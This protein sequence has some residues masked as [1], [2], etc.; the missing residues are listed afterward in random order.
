[1]PGLTDAP[2]LSR[3]HLGASAMNIV[4]KACDI[5]DYERAAL[6]QY[7]L[8]DCAMG[9]TKYHPEKKA[10]G[11]LGVPHHVLHGYAMNVATYQ[12]WDDHRTVYA[13]DPTVMDVIRRSGCSA[14]SGVLLRN[15]PHSNPFVVFPEPIDVTL[16]Q[17][18]QKGKLYGVF[19]YGHVGANKDPNRQYCRT[20]DDD[21]THIGMT[22]LTGVLDD[23]G[24]QIDVDMTRVSVPLAERFTVERAVHDVLNG[25]RAEVDPFNP[26]EV[27]HNSD[28]A[29]VRETKS[30]VETVL[31][32]GLAVLLY[33][34]SDE[35]EAKVKTTPKPKGQRGNRKDR[36]PA[37]AAAP[38]AP[39]TTIAHV[40]WRLGADLRAARATAET[41]Y[42]RGGTG[43]TQPPMQRAGHFKEQA[44]GTRWSLRKLIFVKPYWTHKDQLDSTKRETRVV[45]VR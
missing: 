36:K 39:R 28:P 35:Y 9:L 34:V 30:W 14:V 20:D 38:A 44:Y 32:I 29:T 10:H 3:A 24:D 19:L 42:R 16:D 40:G 33:L 27:N 41:E 18:G 23:E 45:P 6:R 15:L 2:V 26:E 37:R 22:F 4:T 43:R 31:R 17:T 5:F 13:M 7:G 1:M 25:F 11:V 21:M 8:F 12:M